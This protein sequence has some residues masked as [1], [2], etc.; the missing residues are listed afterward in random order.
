MIVLRC[1]QDYCGFGEARVGR[2]GGGNDTLRSR[3]EV[4]QLSVLNWHM[5]FANSI[6]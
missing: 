6:Q 5:S 2:Q 3:G 4:L 1:V